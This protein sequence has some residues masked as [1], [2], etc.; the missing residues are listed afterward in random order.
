MP[1]IRWLLVGDAG[2]HDPELYAEFASL[3]PAH[4]R[5]RAIRQLSP[6]EHA[7][8]HGTLSEVPSPQRWEPETA[9]EV[10]APDGDGLADKLRH[11][12]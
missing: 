1:N 4:V 2:Q 6:G 10:R 7:L 9:P 11:V 5:A 3:Q 8:A 12:L